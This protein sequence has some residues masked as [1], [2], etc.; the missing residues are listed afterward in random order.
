MDLIEAMDGVLCVFWILAEETRCDFYHSILLALPC[1][2]PHR[3]TTRW[4]AR[5]PPEGA[6]TTEAWEAVEAA[7]APEA[8]ALEAET[9]RAE[10][11]EVEAPEAEAPEAEAEAAEA[12]EAPEAPEAEAPEAEAADAA[13]AAGAAEA[14]EAAKHWICCRSFFPRTVP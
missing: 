3:Q 9:P 11:P 7:E 8:E 6:A 5:K 13:K 1:V 2:C 12:A 10:A 4:F 14:A